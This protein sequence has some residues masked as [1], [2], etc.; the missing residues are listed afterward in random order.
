MQIH[1]LRIKKHKSRKRV[2]RGG[3]RGTYCGRGMKGQK[4]RSGVSINPLFEGGR[5][6]LIERLKKM[7][8]FKSPHPKKI[9]IN[10]NDL[11]RNFKAGDTVSVDSLVKIG[12][13]DKIKSK[14]AKVKILGG[15]RL[16]KNITIDKNILLSKSAQASIKKAAGKT[17]SE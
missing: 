12:L 1:Q 10:L 15:G 13:V 14:R 16:T 7:P 8:G 5:S 4:S 9:N 3:K 6:S 11:E 17:L 2:G